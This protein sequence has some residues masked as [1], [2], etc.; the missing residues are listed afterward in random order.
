MKNVVWNGRVNGYLWKKYSKWKFESSTAV[1]IF[2]IMK[3]HQA[4]SYARRIILALPLM[5]FSDDDELQKSG[6]IRKRIASAMGMVG[7]WPRT[8]IHQ[9][10]F[11]RCPWESDHHSKFKMSN[12]LEKLTLTKNHT[13]REQQHSPRSMSSAGQANSDGVFASNA[14]WFRCRAAGYKKMI[15]RKLIM[16][17]LVCMCTIE[18]WWFGQTATTSHTVSTCQGLWKTKK[19]SLYYFIQ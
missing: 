5:F 17:N 7:C 2:S 6:C 13:P 14:Q 12:I 15:P 16:Q 8:T 1:F 10:K 9:F 4:V 18:F 11:L 3:F 19:T